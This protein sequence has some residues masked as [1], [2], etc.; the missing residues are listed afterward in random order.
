MNMP[1]V[2]KG[3]Q[4]GAAGEEERILKMKLQRNSQIT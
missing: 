4:G 2:F 3:Q 1:G